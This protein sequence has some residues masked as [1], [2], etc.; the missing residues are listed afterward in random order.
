MLSGDERFFANSHSAQRQL[1]F[2]DRWSNSQKVGVVRLGAPPSA[3]AI[4]TLCTAERL[5]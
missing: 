1:T 5:I 3:R 2:A 4:C